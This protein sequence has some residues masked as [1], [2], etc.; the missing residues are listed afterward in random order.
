M[1][2]SYLLVNRSGNR[3]EILNF[4][5]RRLF[6]Q[7]IQVYAHT[8]RQYMVRPESFKSPW[9]LRTQLVYRHSPVAFLL[10]LF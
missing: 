2:S 10:L 6:R 9:C 1:I 4:H 5:H 7:Y 3:F 8:I